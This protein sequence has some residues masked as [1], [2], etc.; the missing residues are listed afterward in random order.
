[1]SVSTPRRTRRGNAVTDKRAALLAAATELFA[2]EDMQR[3]PTAAIAEAAGVAKGTLFLYF[4]SREKLINELYLK[5]VADFLGSLETLLDPEA[6][7]ES[8]LHSYWF[9]F[10][11]WHFTHS[12]L[13]SIRLRCEVSSLL[14]AE[15]RA[16]KDQLEIAFSRTFFK[17]ILERKH[18][19]SWRYISYAFIAGPIQVL[20]E[21][22]DKGEIEI[23]DALLE[24]VYSGVRQIVLPTLIEAS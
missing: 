7:P 23:T 9:G 18:G 12:N 22:R 19:T 4:E 8:Q 5:I 24:E 1:M 10:A 20:S 2:R 11:R 17:G 14:T 15:T 16:K 21:L 6:T 3:V 13:A